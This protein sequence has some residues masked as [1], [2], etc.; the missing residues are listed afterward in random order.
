MPKFTKR[1]IDLNGYVLLSHNTIGFLAERFDLNT[2]KTQFWD[3]REDPLR[4][5]GARVPL[6]YGGVG[7]YDN[8]TWLAHGLCRVI[9]TN[10]AE[11]RAYI[12]EIDPRS[13]EG[14]AF[15][16]GAG[17]PDLVPEEVTA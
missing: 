16:E 6:L 15:L 17:Y 13:D 1:W 12:E 9:R 11:T 5:I 8:R 2:N 14:R 4:T 7:V 10:L 3:V